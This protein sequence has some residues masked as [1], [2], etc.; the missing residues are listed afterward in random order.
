MPAHAPC[1]TKPVIH[2]E[3]FSFLINSVWNVPA[4]Y[5]LITRKKKKQKSPGAA[6]SWRTSPRTSRPLICVLQ[7]NFLKP[8]GR[9]FFK[10]HHF[11]RKKMCCVYTVDFLVCSHQEGQDNVLCKK[12]KTTVENRIQQMTSFSENQSIVR[13]LSF[14]EIYKIKFVYMTWKQKWNHPGEQTGLRGEENGSYSGEIS[15]QYTRHLYKNSDLVELSTLLAEY[16][17][18]KKYMYIYIFPLVSMY[19]YM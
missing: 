14:C 4:P 18:M 19:E 16:M 17:L 9:N 3:I 2:Q 5:L 1:S 10:K 15:T 12:M 6:G 11:L 13:F 7:E 8:Q